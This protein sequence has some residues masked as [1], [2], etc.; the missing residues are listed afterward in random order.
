MEYCTKKGECFENGIAN[1]EFSGEFG[2]KKYVKEKIVFT[3]F[4]LIEKVKKPIFINASFIE[5]AQVIRGRFY[6]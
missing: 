5:V 4:L 1:G 6:P 3:R 2:Y